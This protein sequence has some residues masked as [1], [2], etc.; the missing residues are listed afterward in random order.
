MTCTTTP[1]RL[2]PTETKSSCRDDGL[3]GC[4]GSLDTCLSTTGVCNQT[5]SQVFRHSGWANHRRLVY[6]ALMR[7]QQAPSRIISFADCGAEAYVMKSTDDPPRYR[8]AGSSCHDRFCTPCATERAR[9]IAQNVCDKLGS[10]RVRFITFTLRNTDEPLRP[11]LSRLQ[12]SFRA[13][14][15]TN[16]WKRHVTGGVAFLEIKR[17]GRTEAWHPHFHVLVQGKYIDKIRLQNTWHTITGDSY[18]VDIR[19]PGGARNVARYITKYASKPLNSSFLHARARLDE[20]I[21]ALRGVRLCTTFGGWRGVLLVD[22]PDEGCWEN[23]GPLAD[24]IRDASRGDSHAVDV[25]RQLDADKAA[26][27][28][29]LGP[30]LSRPP[31]FTERTPNVDPQLLLLDVPKKLHSSF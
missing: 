3:A 25:L 11:M 27:C 8:T 29:E 22:K 15:R 17:S 14:Q 6:A 30:L 5:L 31:P 18:V 4:P 1:S 24:W 21:H 13:M 26:V 19:C 23:V 9:V 2:D 28:L 7:T 10:T 12:V 20:A 16:L